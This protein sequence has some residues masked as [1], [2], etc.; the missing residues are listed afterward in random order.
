MSHLGGDFYDEAR[1]RNHALS[2]PRLWD[3]PDVGY[4]DGGYGWRLSPA[5]HAEVVAQIVALQEGL[6]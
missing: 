1:E 3:T 4:D 6:R 5:E 2:G